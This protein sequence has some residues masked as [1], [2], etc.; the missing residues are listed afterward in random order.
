M[1][2]Y[3]CQVIPKFICYVYVRVGYYNAK[4]PHKF[5]IMIYFI[6]IPSIF[7]CHQK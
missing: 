1:P 3:L 6:S 2:I 7:A 5:Y 4:V